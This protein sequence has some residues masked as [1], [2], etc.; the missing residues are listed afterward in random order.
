MFEGILPE[1][2]YQHFLGLSIAMNILVSPELLKDYSDS[3][4]RLLKNFIKKGNFF[5]I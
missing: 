2:Q 4:H 5:H 1:D 3:A